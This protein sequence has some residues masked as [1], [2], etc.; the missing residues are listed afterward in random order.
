MFVL[1]INLYKINYDNTYGGVEE[2]YSDNDN[3]IISELTPPKGYTFIAPNKDTDVWNGMSWTEPVY[4]EPPTFESLKQDKINY[5]SN[6][7]NKYVTG[8]YTISLGWDMQFDQR[9]IIMVDGAVRFMEMT[10]QTTGYLT[11]ADNINHYNLSIAQM[12]QVL[13]EMTGAYLQA[14]AYKQTLRN[15]ILS[16]TNE[17]ELSDVIWQLGK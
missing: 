2:S 1:I 5:I 12:K 15:A 10:N 3:I 16:A 8:R 6:S 9:D 4:P 7:F 14:H 13:M 17:F 11:D